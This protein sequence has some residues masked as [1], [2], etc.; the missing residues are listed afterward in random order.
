MAD[1][2]TPKKD[3]EEELFRLRGFKPSRVDVVDRPANLVDGW[4]VLKRED[5]MA[6]ATEIVENEDGTLSTETPAAEPEKPAETKPEPEAPVAPVAKSDPPAKPPAKPAAKPAVKAEN[7]LSRAARSAGEKLL[8]LANKV[9]DGDTVTAGML[10]ELDAVMTLLKG[11]KEQY[12]S[13]TAKADTSGI[14]ADLYTNAGDSWRGLF[15]TVAK[16]VLNPCEKDEDT[17]NTLSAVISMLDDLAEPVR[18]SAP[19]SSA[20]RFTPARTSM[21]LKALT[22]LQEV[23]KDIGASG[24]S[25]LAELAKSDGS[26]EAEVVAK[27]LTE[28]GLVGGTSETDDLRDKVER[29][30]KMISTAVVSK[31]LGADTA[32]PEAKTSLFKGVV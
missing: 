10:R 20:K 12:P 11:A 4:I 24:L 6:D 9:K 32:T 15:R 26:A 31:A 19:T 22:N 13:P 2:P 25:E 1:R 21:L 18:K 27:G 28:L 23:L 16:S 30:E 7:K 5:D 14:E 8:S 29:L 17:V 3:D